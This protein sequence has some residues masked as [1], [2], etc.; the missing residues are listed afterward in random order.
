MKIKYFGK[1]SFGKCIGIRGLY[2]YYYKHRFHVEFE[3]IV[4]NR[5]EA[6]RSLR[7]GA[8]DFFVKKLV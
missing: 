8:R 1:R 7:Q 5:Y 4:R 2:H 3:F 6:H